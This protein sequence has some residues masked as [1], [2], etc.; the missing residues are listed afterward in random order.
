MP[1]ENA[2]RNSTENWVRRHQQMI[3]SILIIL[4]YIILYYI[5]LY[6]IILYYIILYYII[7]YYIIL[8]YII[9][10]TVYLLHVSA[11]CSGN[12]C[13]FVAFD[14]ISSCPMHGHGSLKINGKYLP[15]LHPHLLYPSN[16]FNIFMSLPTFVLKA[17]TAT[18]HTRSSNVTVSNTELPSTA[19]TWKLRVNGSGVRTTHH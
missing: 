7:L 13:A 1:V 9:I 8:Y 12:L 18:L 6:Y 2:L 17:N 14:I 4:Y 3:I 16:T 15:V 10:H 5:I 11:A 19:S